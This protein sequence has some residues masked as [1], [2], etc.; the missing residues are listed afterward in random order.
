MNR[1]HSHDRIGTRPMISNRSK[2]RACSR[3]TLLAARARK[4]AAVEQATATLGPAPSQGAEPH[5][6]R[7]APISS[8]PGTELAGSQWLRAACCRCETNTQ[9]AAPARASPPC[10]R[11]SHKTQQNCQQSCRCSTAL[12]SMLSTALCVKLFKTNY[13][14]C[15]A[16]A[17]HEDGC[18]G[19]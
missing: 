2:Q 3:L 5:R 14:R 17:V 1:G 8:N 10:R 4:H 12:A 6:Q 18:G 19:I 15:V 11:M 13:L 7:R 9:A 16:A